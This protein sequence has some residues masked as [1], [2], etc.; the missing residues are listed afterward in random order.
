MATTTTDWRGGRRVSASETRSFPL[1]TE[2]RSNS[3]P[4][5]SSASGNDTGS[6]AAVTECMTGAA[7]AAC[8]REL[9][10]PERYRQGCANLVRSLRRL[11]PRF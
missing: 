3:G 2:I 9:S 1:A 7:V 10:R 8:S 6:L 5:N 11:G 4:P